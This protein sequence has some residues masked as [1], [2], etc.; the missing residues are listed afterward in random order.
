[1]LPVVSECAI[2]ERHA[3]MI[4]V[5]QRW[6]NGRNS[7]LFFSLFFDER[8]LQKVV[9]DPEVIPAKAGRVRL[10]VKSILSRN[11]KGRIPFFKGMT[12]FS[13]SSDE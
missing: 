12:T 9:I 6:K 13:V 7:R 5:R 4:E 3:I 2:R 11:L 10:S 1:M 8:A